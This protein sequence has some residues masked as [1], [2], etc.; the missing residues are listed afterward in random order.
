MNRPPRGPGAGAMVRVA[1]RLRLRW[2][3]AALGVLTAVPLAVTLAG[4]AGARPPAPVALGTVALTAGLVV[5]WVRHATRNG[6]VPRRHRAA[7][8]AALVLGALVAMPWYW[9]RHVW[10]VR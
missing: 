9:W 8:V 5:H 1:R 10:R 3:K 2:R 6:H 4:A 7:W